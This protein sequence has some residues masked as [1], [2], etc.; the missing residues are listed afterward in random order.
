LYA[1]SDLALAVYRGATGVAASAGVLDTATTAAHVSPAV[2]APGGSKWLVTFWADKS[3]GTTAWTPPGTQT[4]RSNKFGSPS[5]AMSGLL[6][7]SNADVSGST[8][9]LTATAN[10]STNRALSFSLVLQ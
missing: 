3:G 4:F 9:G 7:D 10:S 6:V 5:G 1:K 8:G 2:N